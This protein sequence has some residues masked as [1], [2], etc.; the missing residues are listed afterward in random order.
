M[1]EGLSQ[2]Y[3]SM[4][5]VPKHEHRDR[6]DQELECLRRMVRDLEIEVQG[7]RR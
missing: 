4:L 6:R 2:T 1:R 5:D 3:Q 7:R